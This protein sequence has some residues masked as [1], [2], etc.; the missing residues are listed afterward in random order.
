MY[1]VTGLCGLK[2]RSERLGRKEGPS[3]FFCSADVIHRSGR[4]LEA[5]PRLLANPLPKGRTEHA[6]IIAVNPSSTFIAEARVVADTVGILRDIENRLDW[7]VS[8]TARSSNLAM[9]EWG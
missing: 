8:R 3:V 2:R 7:E 6:A 9:L 5:Q 4:P 1:I